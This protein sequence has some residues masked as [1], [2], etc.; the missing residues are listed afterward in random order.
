MHTA[1]QSGRFDVFFW[2]D[3]RKEKERQGMAGFKFFKEPSSLSMI[4]KHGW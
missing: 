1:E 4:K 2:F 3:L